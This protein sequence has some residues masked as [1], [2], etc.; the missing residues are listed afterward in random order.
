MP[1]GGPILACPLVP[2]T[3]QHFR[4]HFRSYKKST[5]T[6]PHKQQK[7]ASTSPNSSTK[8][9]NNQIRSK[10]TEGPEKAT[11]WEVNESQSKFLDGT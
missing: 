2:L 8:V 3:D 10:T 4:T 7:K 1:L 11:R 9:I 5:N 6:K